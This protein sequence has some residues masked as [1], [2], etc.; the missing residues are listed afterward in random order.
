M[1]EIRFQPLFGAKELVP[2]NVYHVIC[3]YDITDESNIKVT[4]KKG[5][6]HQLKKLL[7]VKQILLVSI[8]GNA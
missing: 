1:G 6:N 7:I 5:N 8:S 4:R 2:K 3:H